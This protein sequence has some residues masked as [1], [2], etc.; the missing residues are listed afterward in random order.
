MKNIHLIFLG[1][2]LTFSIFSCHKHEDEATTANIT[3]MEPGDNDTIAFGSEIHVEGTIS[4]NGELHGYTLEI[5]N[6]GDNSIV[7]SKSSSTHAS[8]YAFHEHW[9]NNVSDTT[10][11]RIT[12]D[13]MLNH[14]GLKTS[15]SINVVCLPQ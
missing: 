2:V 9:M 1:L 5:V 4:S 3:L 7:F 10:N 6:S 14:D 8:S 15:K 11:M 13:A 12:I